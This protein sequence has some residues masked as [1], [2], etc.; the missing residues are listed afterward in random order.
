MCVVSDGQPS[1]YFTGEDGIRENAAAI[2]DA[3]ALGAE[4]FGV[5]VAAGAAE[6]FI[7]MYGKDYFA[8]ITRPDDLADQM[9][10]LIKTVVK[11]W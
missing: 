7:R 8:S 6:P 9:A 10:A 2:R 1:H 3:R 11:G 5:A 4:V